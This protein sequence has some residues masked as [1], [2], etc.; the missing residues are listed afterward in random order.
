MTQIKKLYEKLSKKPTPTDIRF[1]EIDKLLTHFG[2][3]CRQPSKG[4]SHYIYTH[5]KIDIC[6]SIPKSNQI[7]RA[8]IKNAVRA[9]EK[10]IEIDGGGIDNEE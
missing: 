5:P 9:I 3:T 2:F 10:L 4:G 6:P 7:K 8:Y 1:E